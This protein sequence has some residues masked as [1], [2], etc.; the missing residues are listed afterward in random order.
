MTEPTILTGITIR[1]VDYNQYQSDV[2]R[3]LGRGSGNFG[4]GQTPESRPVD[5][6]KKITVN[7]WAALKNDILRCYKHINNT[8]PSLVDTVEGNKV[9]ISPNPDV[10]KPTITSPYTQYNS[11]VSFITSNRLAIPI[12]R[13]KNPSSP[14]NVRTQ[15]W[16]GIYGQYWRERLQAIIT[17]SFP[18]SDDARYFFNSGGEII[19]RSTRTGGAVSPQN[20][21]WTNF[22][23]N[24]VGET[25]FGGATPFTGTTPLN[26]QNFYRLTNQYTSPYVDRT[27]SGLYTANRFRCWCRAINAPGNNNSSG[28]ASLI[29]FTVEWLDDKTGINGGPDYVDGTVSLFL[30]TGIAKPPPTGVLTIN[31]PSVSMTEITP[32]GV[33]PNQTFSITPS[34]RRVDEGQSVT[35]T[36]N[37]TNVPNGTVLWWNIFGGPGINVANPNYTDNDFVASSGNFTVFNNQGNFT[38]TVSNDY[39]TEGEQFFYAE[40]RSNSASGPIVCSSDS[41]VINDTTTLFTFRISANRTATTDLRSLAVNAAWDQISKLECIIDNVTLLGTRNTSYNRTD[42]PIK[43]GDVSALTI[44]GNFPN[45]LILRNNGRIYGPGGKGGNAPYGAGLVGGPAITVTSTF[46]SPTF[47]LINNGR[48]EGGGG[49]GGGGIRGGGGGG[50]SLGVGGTGISPGA[51]GSNATAVL[52]GNPGT[53]GY[54]EGTGFGAGGRGGLMGEAGLSGTGPY[55]ANI[56]QNNGGLAG[57]SIIGIGLITSITIPTGSQGVIT[58]E[59]LNLPGTN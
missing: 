32:L 26:G 11:F 42:S 53:G 28:G 20:T 6:D 34:D 37:T 58:G 48:I 59:Q 55:S 2:D 56:I 14:D 22:L 41:I 31:A 18:S 49:G 12:L 1:T 35:F 25:V 15:T 27:A 17:V 36:V 3:V 4:Y 23:E 38:V 46:S 52:P 24:A 8:V 43:H 10:S 29:E 16:P 13:D 45:G 54:P 5:L 44:R 9:T 50:A 19:I 39:N 57:Y 30:Q 21:E 47:I 40:V 33:T 51:N 7:E